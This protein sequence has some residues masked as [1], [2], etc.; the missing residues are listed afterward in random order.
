M[1]GLCNFQ[2]AISSRPEIPEDFMGTLT[3]LPV[4]ITGSTKEQI[5]YS[6]GMPGTAIDFIPQKSAEFSTVITSLYGTSTEMEVCVMCERKYYE[7]AEDRLQQGY[8]LAA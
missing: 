6:L 4:F 7:K 5:A 1:D 2:R 3:Q 8:L